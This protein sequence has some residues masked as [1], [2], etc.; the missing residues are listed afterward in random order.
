[1]TNA[2]PSRGASSHGTSAPAG[3]LARVTW[4]QA[5][6]DT[7][8][9]LANDAD[10]RFGK[11]REASHS[12]DVHDAR[13]ATRRLRTAAGIYRSAIGQR[14]SRKSERELRRVARLLGAVR[15]LDVLLATLDDW[16]HDAGLERDEVAPLRRTLE[17]DR[18][19][20]DSR[21][22]SEL[23]RDR[24]DGALRR[25]T[26]LADRAAVRA[27]RVPDG[28]D[29]PVEASLV[30]HRAPA[31]IWGAFG[32]LLDHRVRPEIADPATIHRMRLAAKKLRYTLEAFEDALGGG[33][34]QRIE[35]V[36]AVQEFRGRDARC[37]R[38]GRTRA[39]DAG[40]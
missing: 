40:R 17:A 20:A 22:R 8:L 27:R 11:L 31:V 14:R 21:L 33:F 37:G 10:K 29:P 32:D 19:V 35:Q 9:D 3:R 25:M 23:E 13:T 15:D 5:A 39:E 28:D 16:E 6:A 38:R 4:G 36:T 1:M 24:V 34:A 12:D 7:V 2:A 30:G 18:T 26:A